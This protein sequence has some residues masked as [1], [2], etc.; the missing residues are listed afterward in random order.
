MVWQQEHRLIY[1]DFLG[2]YR[3]VLFLLVGLFLVLSARLFY[4]QI[5]KGTKYR[6]LSEQQRTHIVLE[7]APR[8]MIYDCNGSVLVGNKNA[9]VATFYPFTQGKS[10]P[11]ADELE[12]LKDI[13]PESDKD[14]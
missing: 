11:D 10:A 6:E 12:R 13:F 14:L 2:R 4:L 5:L 8:G 9:F 1:E 3:F 7:R